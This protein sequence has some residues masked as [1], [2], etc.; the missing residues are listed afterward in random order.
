ML[1]WLKTLPSFGSIGLGLYSFLGIILYMPIGPDVF[2]IAIAYTSGKFPLVEIISTITGYS[3]GLTVS[4]YIGYSG[5]RIIRKSLKKLE[6]FLYRYVFICSFVAALT[7][8]PLREFSLLAGYS[9][10]KFWRF[11][12][13]CLLGLLIRFSLECILSLIF[14][15]PL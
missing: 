8:V 4:F 15:N 1:T 12:L 11:I 5:K 6:K 14:K 9:R 2:L 10:V 3:L 13:G 7:P